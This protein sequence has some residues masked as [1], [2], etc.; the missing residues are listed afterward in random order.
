M[1]TKNVTFSLPIEVVNLLHAKIGKRELSKFA[2][3]A[4]QKA[5][6]EEVDRLRAAYAAADK[7]P[8]RLETINDWA[9][10]DNEEWE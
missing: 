9:S 5:L 8:D 2:T 1:K 4:I 3:R 10:L 7:D 6:T